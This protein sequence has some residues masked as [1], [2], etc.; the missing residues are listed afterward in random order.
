MPEESGGDDAVPGRALRVPVIPV[1]P[2]TRPSRGALS[3]VPGR[4]RA[5]HSSSSSSA[6]AGTSACASRSSW[7]TLPALTA[8]D[9]ASS[10]WVAP[11][12]TVPSCRGTMYTGIPWTSPR[13]VDGHQGAQVLRH[14]KA[15]DVAVHRPQRQSKAVGQAVKGSRMQAVGHHGFPCQHSA[16]AG[17]PDAGHRPVLPQQSGRAFRYGI[18]VTGTGHREFRGFPCRPGEGLPQGRYQLPRIHLVVGRSV[19]RARDRGAQQGFAA[20]GFAHGQQFNLQPVGPL[21]GAQVHQRPPVG[22]VGTHGEGRRR[23]VSGPRP[24]LR[25]RRRQQTPASAMMLQA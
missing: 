18:P 17:Q 24:P 3:G 10:R 5:V 19:Q 9:S 21:H 22:G 7:Y 13:T 8:S 20:A 25:L 11:M 2:R 14:G 6:T 16:A 23:Q 1:T 4:A 12:T 15:Q